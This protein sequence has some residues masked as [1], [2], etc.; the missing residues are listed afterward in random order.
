M[1]FM[2]AA[3]RGIIAC[4]NPPFT[5]DHPLSFCIY[6]FYYFF[7][8]SAL[9][10]LMFYSCLIALLLHCLIFG[11]VITKMLL[12]SLPILPPVCNDCKASSTTVSVA[13]EPSPMS[14]VGSEESQTALLLVPL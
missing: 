3:R 14:L 8:F 7:W 12:L 9:S 5:C 10:S 6:K 13:V 1:Q 4:I 2:Y 11:T